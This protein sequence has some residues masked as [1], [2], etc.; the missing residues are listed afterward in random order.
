MSQAQHPELDRQNLEY[1]HSRVFTLLRKKFGLPRDDAEDVVA[2]ALMRAVEKLPPKLEKPLAAWL[3][4]TAARI[5]I[6]E[7]RSR[8]RQARL[9]LEAERH[10]LHLVEAQ[11]TTPDLEL[12]HWRAAAARW[13]LRDAMETDDRRFF[14]TWVQQHAC[15]ISRST[16][17]SRLGCTMAQYEAAKK[18]LKLRIAKLLDELDMS[19]EEL[20]TSDAPMDVRA[21]TKAS[22]NS[23]ETA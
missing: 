16:A 1:A 20:L 3:T 7:L 4:R 9:M 21:T 10:H 13:R 12:E 22:H 8:S 19:V 11:G 14:D 17:I 6:D 23:E 2:I 18:R 15:E 5:A